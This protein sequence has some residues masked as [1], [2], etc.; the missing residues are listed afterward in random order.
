MPFLIYSRI[1]MRRNL[2]KISTYILTRCI[3]YQPESICYAA[4]NAKTS[5]RFRLHLFFIPSTVYRKRP[6]LCF[7][8]FFMKIVKKRII[9][10]NYFNIYIFHLPMK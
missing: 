10:L 9:H 5:D 2:S 7:F 1:K 6:N 8:Y 4:M 3:L